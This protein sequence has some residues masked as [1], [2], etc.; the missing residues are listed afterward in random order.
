[1]SAPSALT[2]AATVTSC[3]VTVSVA[4]T[5][6]RFMTW[7]RVIA[8]P[9]PIVALPVPAADPSPPERASVLA[10]AARVTAPAAVIDVTAGV[11]IVSAWMF[12]MSIPTAAA[13]LTEPS[14]VSAFGFCCEP[15]PWPP[16]VVATES[17]CVRSPCAIW[18]TPVPDAPPGFEA[19]P[20]SWSFSGAPAAEAAARALEDETLEARSVTSAPAVTLRASVEVD[21]WLA[22]VRAKPTPIAA[23]VAFKV[24]AVA[25]VSAAACCVAV[26][27]RLRLSESTPV[28]TCVVV[29]T[30]ESVI[31]TAGASATLPPFAP[32]FA[33]VVAASVAVAVRVRSRAPVSETPSAT[34][35][36]VVSVMRL[37]ATDAPIPALPVATT[38]SP[39]GS[40]R[41]VLARE[42]AAVSVASPPVSTTVP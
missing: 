27:D 6:A 21:V 8:T 41:T 18:S 16:L 14:L 31:A 17:A 5:C 19:S 37:R 33:S 28:P 40:A 24:A 39:W 35:A 22:I 11:M 42:L 38:P 2:V 1:M 7:T 23:S 30:F 32:I 13:T 36:A 26:I 3:A 15:E 25:W 29:V 34:S 20:E 4:G 10:D 9:A 12:A